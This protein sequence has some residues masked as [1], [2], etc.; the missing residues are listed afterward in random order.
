MTS[1]PGDGPEPSAANARTARLRRAPRFGRFIG[2]GVVIGAVLALVLTL[3]SQPA[4][5]AGRGTVLIYLLTFL[6]LLGGV[7]G[8]V[9]AVVADR[10]SR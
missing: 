10:R 6:V 9:T 1:A 4:P 8:A 7:V 3:V 5:G 2:T